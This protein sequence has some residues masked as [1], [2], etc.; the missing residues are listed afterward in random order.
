MTVAVAMSLAIGRLLVGETARAVATVTAGFVT[1][2]TVTS[3]GSGYTSEPAVIFSG[4]GGSGASRKVILAGDKVALILVLTAGTG[5]TGSPTVMVEAPPKA[6]NVRL[7]LVPEL[8]VEGPAGSL[9][10]VEAA[11]NLTGPWTTWTNVTVGAEGMVLVDLS[12]GSATRFYR[13]MA[14][15]LLALFGSIPGRS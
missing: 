15:G 10:K 8:T 4:G 13:S 11:W 2:L 6:L 9:A 7:R 12:P 3:G 5:Y 14:V 1:G